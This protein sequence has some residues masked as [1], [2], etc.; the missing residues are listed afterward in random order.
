MVRSEQ[1]ALSI[2]IATQRSPVQH[3]APA[4]SVRHYRPAMEH[5]R[6]TRRNVAFLFS[7]AIS[8]THF[9]AEQ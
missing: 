7:P 9:L 2:A 4:E 6:H 5:P 1:F 8:A 3:G